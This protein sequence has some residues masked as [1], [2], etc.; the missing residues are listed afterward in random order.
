MLKTAIAPRPSVA[1]QEQEATII[2]IPDQ[3]YV[4]AQYKF[5]RFRIITALIVGYSAF[6]IVRQNFSIAAP[7]MLTEFGY[8]KTDLGWVFTGFSVIY[9][10]SKFASGMLCDR[11]NVR[12]FMTLG[13]LGAALA[14]LFI[15]FSSSIV[16]IGLLYALN[17]LFQSTGWPPVTRSLTHWYA[18]RQLGTRWGIVNASHQIGSTIILNGGPF[19]LLYFA[20]RGVFIIPAVICVILAGFVFWWLRDSPKSIGLPSIEEK[21]GL[22]R[23][24]ETVDEDKRSYREVFVENILTN[25]MLWIICMANF[26]VY[27]IRMGFFNWAPT[28][29]QETKGV[30]LQL[31]GAQ[32]TAFEVAGL[33]GGLLA[34]VLSDKIFRGRRGRTSFYFMV[35]LTIALLAFCYAPAY[36]PGLDFVLF[37]TMGFLVYGPQVLV[38][39]AGAELGSKRAAAAGAGLT[40]T[41]GY[42]GGA[43]AGVGVG[44]MA[45]TWGWQAAFLSFVVCSVLGAICFLFAWNQGKQ[46]SEK[47]EPAKA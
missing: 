18:P 38:G 1:H 43:V 14:N 13:L 16:V 20:W 11:V 44:F 10:L 28:F 31:A 2:Q 32:V 27:I 34:G 46:P 3:A 24:G 29:L 21:E 17:G 19:I 23:E 25:K 30:S 5:W 45:D 9:G 37:F 35:I 40:G 36:V 7:G 41:F 26:F 6:Y 15:G 39:I 47:K 42:M 33:I 22:V 4:N 12:Y 8:T